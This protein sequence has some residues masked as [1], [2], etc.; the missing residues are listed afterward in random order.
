MSKHDALVGE[1][2]ALDLVNTRPADTD[3]LASIESLNAWLAL[4]TA[5]FPDLAAFDADTEAAL[6]TVVA[7]RTAVTA[8]VDA[9]LAERPVPTSAVEALNAAQRTAPA[10]TRLS[11]ADSGFTA[12]KE[13]TGPS[14]HRL[15]ARLAAAAAELL[16][17]EAIAK[18]KQ[19]EA[20][21]C[22]L[23]FVPTHPKRRWCSAERCGNRVRVARYYRHNRKRAD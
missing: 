18:L 3:H 4:E 21:D 7:V 5:R 10:F 12:A 23:V 13:H 11:L 17:S 6:A 22:R 9:L 8:V 1:P 2:L 20:D 16:A 14:E 19:C 15:A